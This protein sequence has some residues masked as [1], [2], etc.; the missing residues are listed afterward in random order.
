[1]PNKGPRERG[2][3]LGELIEKEGCRNVSVQNMESKLFYFA[4]LERNGLCTQNNKLD[5]FLDICP[6][7][8]TADR[9]EAWKNLGITERFRLFLVEFAAFHEVCINHQACRAHKDGDGDET[10]CLHSRLGVDSDTDDLR[11][12]EDAVDGCL[13]LLNNGVGLRMVANYTTVHATLDD[14]VHLSDAS[15]DSDNTSSASS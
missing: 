3:T 8:R 7:R 11:A 6:H 1:M 14:T 13:V 2:S 10:L 15:R 5:A 12:L 9:E 4:V